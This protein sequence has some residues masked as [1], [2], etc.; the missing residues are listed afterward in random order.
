MAIRISR[1]ERRDHLRLSPE[2]GEKP[3][4][5][6]KVRTAFAVR[7]APDGHRNSVFPVYAGSPP[8]IGASGIKRAPRK[9]YAPAVSDRTWSEQTKSLSLPSS[10][11]SAAPAPISRHRFVLCR[12]VVMFDH[13]GV[14]PSTPNEGHNGFAGQMQEGHGKF[15]RSTCSNKQVS[16]VELRR[17]S[18]TAEASAAHR[19]DD[20]A[21]RGGFIQITRPTPQAA[22]AA[23]LVF[24]ALRYPANPRPANPISSIAQVEGSGTAPAATANPIA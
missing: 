21:T 7:K 19:K 3:G 20:E 24:R 17:Q 6:Q 11:P 12:A 15:V 2:A 16:G 4:A 5:G 14:A 8:R 9:A 18:L 13:R 10:D 22:V 23:R 1:I